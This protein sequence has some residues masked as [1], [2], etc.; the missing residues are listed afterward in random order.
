MADIPFNIYK[1]LVVLDAYHKLNI[2]PDLKKDM[3]NYILKKLVNTR[4]FIAASWDPPQPQEFPKVEIPELDIR[5]YVQATVDVESAI[6]PFEVVLLQ[7]GW[8]PK[9]VLILEKKQLLEYLDRVINA[10]N[11]T[12]P[13]AETPQ[14]AT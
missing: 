12:P 4:N 8:A 6:V 1:S 2:P 7:R 5:N 13:T 3:K 9:D 11:E 14:E 10:L